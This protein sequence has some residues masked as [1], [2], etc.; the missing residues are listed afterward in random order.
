[1]QAKSLRRFRQ[2]QEMFAALLDYTQQEICVVS[3]AVG[4]I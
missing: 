3:Q 1:M 2:M 4:R